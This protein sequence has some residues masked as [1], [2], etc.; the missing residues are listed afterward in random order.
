MRHFLAMLIAVASLILG[1]IPAQAQ[2]TG[3]G[4]KSILGSVIS[5]LMGDIDRGDLRAAIWVDPDGCEHWVIDDGLEGYMS[6]HLDK[7]GNPVCRGVNGE[8]IC[9]T[10]DQP[11]MFG[12]GS[13]RI[14]AASRSELVAYFKDIAGQRIFVDGHTDN[15]GSDDV[16]LRLSLRRAAAIA[17]LAVENGV[18]AEARGFGEQVPVADN[19]TRDGRAMNRRVE[20][21]CS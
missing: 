3:R 21:N 10:F 15:V 18:N 9:K 12:S 11:T 17:D 6:A 14:N 20:I 19:G 8:G 4:G 5:V 7:D 13:A 2:D 16:N 1:T